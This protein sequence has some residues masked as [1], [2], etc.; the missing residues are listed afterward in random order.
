MKYTKQKLLL[1]QTIQDTET[2]ATSHLYFGF[3]K[4]FLAHI[5][6]EDKNYS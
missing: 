1:L 6:T 5:K 2:G 4:L 3:L